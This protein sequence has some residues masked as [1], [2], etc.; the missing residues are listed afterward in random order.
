MMAV[1]VVSM[2]VS[3]V[4]VVKSMLVSVVST[5]VSVVKSMLVSVVLTIFFRTM[6]SDGDTSSGRESVT[7]VIILKNVFPKIT[8]TTTCR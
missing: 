7:T 8:K 3:M 4:L 5:V 6:V 1:S 2:V